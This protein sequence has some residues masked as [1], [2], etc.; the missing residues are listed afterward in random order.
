MDNDKKVCNFNNALS[1]NPSQFI[2]NLYAV[3]YVEF[4]Q[5]GS[6]RLWPR[7]VF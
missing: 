3:K 5:V 6:A 1:L 4:C 2:Y 7:V